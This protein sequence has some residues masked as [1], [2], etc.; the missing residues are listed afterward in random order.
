[1]YDGREHLSREVAKELRRHF[2]GH[3]FE[4]EVPRAISLAEAPSFGQPIC[5]YDPN[6]IGARAYERLAQEIIRQEK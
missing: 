4:V 1:M 5:L 6:S 3:V 2:I